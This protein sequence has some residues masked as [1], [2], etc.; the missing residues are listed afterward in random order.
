VSYREFNDRQ[1]RR[2]QV[3]EISPATVSSRLQAE[4]QSANGTQ[5]LP[6]RRRD[7]LAHVAAGLR[8]GWLAFQG[9]TES[10][11]LAP[12]PKGW[13]ALSDEE[14]ADLATT[15]SPVPLKSRELG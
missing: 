4:R 9:E 13:L 6:D 11:R 3:W 10:R 14:L 5:P 15:A 7:P 12:I 1:G 2:W 8:D